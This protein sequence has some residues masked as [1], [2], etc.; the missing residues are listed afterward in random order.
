MHCVPSLM[1]CC[2]LWSQCSKQCWS[3]AKRRKS[4]ICWTSLGACCLRTKFSSLSAKKWC[5]FL[6]FPPWKKQHHCRSSLTLAWSHLLC[7]TFG[8]LTRGN[9]RADDLSSDMSLQ[10]LRVQCLHGGHEQRDREE[11]FQ[12]FKDG[13]WR[14]WG[15]SGPRI[16]ATGMFGCTFTDHS[17]DAWFAG[18]VRILVATDLASRGLDV[19]DITHVFNYDF[20]R[21][22]EEYVHRVGRT[23]RAGYLSLSAISGV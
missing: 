12:D 22:I 1:W 3:S 18:R 8:V 14:A 19:H 20:P 11:A 6:S 16:D 2:R 21:N 17:Q 10:G 23:G 7:C 4:L 15:T 5:A 9:I 13:M